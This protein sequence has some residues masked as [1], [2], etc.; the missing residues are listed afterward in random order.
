VEVSS[1]TDVSGVYD[2]S[3]FGAEVSRVGTGVQYGPTGTLEK[4]STG[5][6][7]RQKLGNWR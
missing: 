6:G 5:P 2:A 7:V 3:I 1:V 4:L